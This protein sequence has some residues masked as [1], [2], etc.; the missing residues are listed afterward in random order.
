MPVEVTYLTTNQPQCTFP[1]MPFDGLREK[2]VE[3]E[4]KVVKK[5]K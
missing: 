1:L 5:G 4:E 2:Q 3:V